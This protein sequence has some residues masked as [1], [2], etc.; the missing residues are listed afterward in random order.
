MIA[1][2]YVALVLGG[3]FVH[4]AVS[5]DNSTLRYSLSQVSTWLVTVVGLAAGAGLWRHY[6]WAWWLGVVAAYVNVFFMLF[7]LGR[8]VLTHF[9][10]TVYLVLGLQLAFLWTAARR[11]TFLLCSR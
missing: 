3:I 1:F 4:Y 2:A 7:W 6:R 11:A 8:H 9:Q 10:L 5:G